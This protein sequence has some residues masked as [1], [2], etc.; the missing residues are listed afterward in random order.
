MID[1]FV[2]LTPFLL[3]GVMALL[4]F[5][6][7]DILFGLTHL[8][9]NVPKTTG[10]MPLS[11]A[12]GGADFILTVN[13]SGFINESKVRWNN[14]ERTTT[15]VSATELTAQI[16]SGDLAPEGTAEV[17]VFTP[18]ED[19]GTSN[20]QYFTIVVEVVVT[21]DN[22]S[23]PGTGMD[24]PLDGVYM[25][26]ISQ[27]RIDF[28]MGKWFWKGSGVGNSIFLGPIS[29]TNPTSGSF[30]FANAPPGGRVLVRLRVISDTLLSG[31]ISLQD[32]VN[33]PTP[34]FPVPAGAAPMFVP[35]GW[36]LASPTVTVRSDIGW[37]L[38]IDTIVYQ[39]PP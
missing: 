5:V 30:T 24:S 16:T 9:T 11:G 23:P 3:L 36:Q 6:G 7:C 14:S 34:P 17:T 15:F 35:T 22:P 10:I 26:N 28:G 38:A 13:G 20:P 29:S 2:L 31:N 18:G 1:P 19:G 37:D 39:G 8:S 27:G 12:L 25:D 33:P 4:R 21:F 32:G